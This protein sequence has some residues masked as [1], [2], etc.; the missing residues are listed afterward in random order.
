MWL[1]LYRVLKASMLGDDDDDVTCN[2]ASIDEHVGFDTKCEFV[3]ECDY[4]GIYNFN[5][6]Y[7]CDLEENL[8]VWL[9]MGILLIVLCFYV[10]G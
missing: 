1:L 4:E 6:F 5:T 7:Y 10:L 9:P 3:Q 8:A 2:K